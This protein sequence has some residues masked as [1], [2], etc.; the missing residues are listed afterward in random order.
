MNER[1]DKEVW[2]IRFVAT[3][4]VEG[5]GAWA[6]CIERQHA[7]MKHTQRRNLS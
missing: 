5:P 2:D 4:R 1:R 7:G 3:R 6:F